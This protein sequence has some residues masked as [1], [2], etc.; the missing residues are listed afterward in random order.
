MSEIYYIKNKPSSVDPKKEE[1]VR[2]KFIPEYDTKT[3]HIGYVPQY[4]IDDLK[5]EQYRRGRRR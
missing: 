5:K 1:I 3:A 4:I 2:D